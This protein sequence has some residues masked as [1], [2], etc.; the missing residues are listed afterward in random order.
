MPGRRDAL[1]ERVQGKLDT[2]PVVIVSGNGEI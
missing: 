2:P 1:I